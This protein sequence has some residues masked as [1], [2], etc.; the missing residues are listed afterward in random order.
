MKP[1]F[2]TAGQESEVIKTNGEFLVV[3]E[4]DFLKK[5][6]CKESSCTFSEYKLAFSY[7]REIHES[8]IPSIVKSTYLTGTSFDILIV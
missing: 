1:Q 7:D 2:E 8:I 5:T 6:G 3:G 4:N